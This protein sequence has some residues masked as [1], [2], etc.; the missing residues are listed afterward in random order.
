MWVSTSFLGM[1]GA[2]SSPTGF[3]SLMG[4]FAK[5]SKDESDLQSSA[6]SLSPARPKQ[7]QAALSRS[8]SLQQREG[9]QSHDLSS[10]WAGHHSSQ[11]R[12]VKGAGGHAGR[13]HASK[14][15]PC[16]HIIIDQWHAFSLGCADRTSHSEVTALAVVVSAPAK[17][18]VNALSI[19][20]SF[21][22]NEHPASLPLAPAKHN[23]S[24]TRS[25]LLVALFLFEQQG[26]SLSMCRSCLCAIC[27]GAAPLMVLAAQSTDAPQTP[28]KVPL[29]PQ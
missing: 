29:G 13:Q 17:T 20:S 11:S 28:P 8:L 12:I 25:A 14:K 22:N 27:L 2:S 23:E 4:T 16:C 19:V 3:S 5:S 24:E 26:S 7:F 21:D 1:V 18:S 10:T 15:L 9:E 6:P